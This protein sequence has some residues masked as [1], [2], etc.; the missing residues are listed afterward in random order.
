MSVLKSGVSEREESRLGV[1][2][3]R[4]VGDVLV[5]CPAVLD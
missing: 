3:A 2:V 4:G 1:V 5:R